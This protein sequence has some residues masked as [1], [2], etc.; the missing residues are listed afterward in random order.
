MRE[1]NEQ[2]HSNQPR[3]AAHAAPVVLTL[4]F[5]G[6]AASCGS[7]PLAELS[8][9]ARLEVKLD[10]NIRVVTPRRRIK[11]YVDLQNQTSRSIDF[12]GLTIELRVSPR[13]DTESVALRQTWRYGGLSL[14][15]LAPERRLTVPIVPERGVE[16]PLEHLAPGDYQIVAVVDER[17][18]SA[19]YDVHVHRP[20]LAGARAARGSPKPAHHRTVSGARGVGDF[21]PVPA[22]IRQTPHD[23]GEESR[24]TR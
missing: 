11:F 1:P 12:A 7:V 13:A 23:A 5:A 18:T 3:R 8:D 4:L 10:A 16:L 24:W 21:R 17:F 20:D 14:P 2:R 15:S 9:E 22:P 6:F 19:P